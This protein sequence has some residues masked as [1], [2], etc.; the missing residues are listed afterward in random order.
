V[1]VCYWFPTDI[2]FFASNPIH[3]DIN[4]KIVGSSCMCCRLFK[5]LW[6]RLKELL[7]LSEEQGGLGGKVC[8]CIREVLSRIFRIPPRKC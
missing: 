3:Q 5:S 4:L 2:M 1:A 7:V 8:N 6:Q